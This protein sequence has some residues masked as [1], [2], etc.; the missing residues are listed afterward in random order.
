MNRRPYLAA[1]NF[2]IYP[3]NSL[4]SFSVR[5]PLHGGIEVPALPSA[6]IFSSS[7]SFFFWVFERVKSAGL[8]LSPEDAGPSPFPS[9][10]WQLA[11]REIKSSLVPVFCTVALGNELTTIFSVGVRSSA[12]PPHKT[13]IL[14]NQ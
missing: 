4:I 9:F 14:S 11:H 12:L 13:K 6:I 1:D 3:T 7:A 10:P 8:E 5:F 2:L